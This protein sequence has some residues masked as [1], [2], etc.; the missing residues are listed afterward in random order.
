M[1]LFSLTF[2]NYLDILI[3]NIFSYLYPLKW[4]EVKLLIEFCGLVDL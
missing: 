2:E 4:D 3:C 1:R